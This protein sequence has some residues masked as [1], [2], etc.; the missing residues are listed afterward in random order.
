MVENRDH[1]PGGL[2]AATMEAKGAPLALFATSA[3]LLF[4]G[5]A[6][7]ESLF[8]GPDDP[9][10]QLK[11]VNPHFLALLGYVV[12]SGEALV[13]TVAPIEIARRFWRSSPGGAALGILL[14]GPVLHGSK[15]LEGVLIST[16]IALVIAAAYVL[17]RQTSVKLAVF[18]ALSLKWAFWTSAL[19]TILGA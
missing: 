15:G 2:L 16:W 5:A 3:A 13:F 8:P 12:L 18:Q 14:Y 19:V 11:A 17:Q 4:G 6:L 1:R 10:D 7:L 9:L